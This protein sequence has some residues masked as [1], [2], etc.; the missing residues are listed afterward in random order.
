VNTADVA[1][2]ERALR[3]ECIYSTPACDRLIGWTLFATDAEGQWWIVDTRSYT[4]EQRHDVLR[5]H[6]AS[7]LLELLER[8]L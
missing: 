1:L 7:A 4:E 2:G 8:D 5:D 6:V 3:L